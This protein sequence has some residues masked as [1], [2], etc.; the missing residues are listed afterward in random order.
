M[1]NL[2][3]SS[4]WVL[5]T[6]I[7]SP[8]VDSLQN[9]TRFSPQPILRWFFCLIW[10][11][12]S[13][14]CQSTDKNTHQWPGLILSSSTAKLLSQRV[15]WTQP[16]LI[17]SQAAEPESGPDSA[18]PHPQPSCW[19]RE[20]PGL[21]LSSSTA[22]LLSQRVAWTQPFL[23]HSQAAEPE[24]GLDSSFPHPQPSCWAR[25]WP[26]LSL[27]SFTAKLLSQACCFHY[28][29]IYSARVN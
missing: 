3:T 4:Q 17:H 28:A 18:F 19:A 14:Q 16:F 1:P 26:G 29:S 10:Q 15:A 6:V 2:V 5:L 8:Y 22:K 27:S 9:Y 13:H 7:L 23:I 24:S 21:S 20:W 12:P 25:E 11:K